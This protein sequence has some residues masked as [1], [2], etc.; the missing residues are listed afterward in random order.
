MWGLQLENCW[1]CSDYFTTCLCVP[2]RGEEEE[3]EEKEKEVQE[4]EEQETFRG[5]R[6]GIRVRW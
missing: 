3:K 6:A 4:E 5:Q 1:L 2:N